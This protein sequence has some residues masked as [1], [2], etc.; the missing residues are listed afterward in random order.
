M[1]LNGVC[2]V[3]AY[4]GKE[5]DKYVKEGINLAVWVEPNYFVFNRLIERTSKYNIKNVWLPLLLSDINDELVDFYLTNNEESSSFM[6]LGNKHRLMYPSITIVGKIKIITKRFDIY[7]LNQQDFSWS[8]I[9]TLV[10]DCQG[11]DLKVL[12]GFGD[13]LNSPSLKTIQAEV[14]FGNMYINNPTEEEI[15]EFLKNYGFRKDRWFIV[16]NGSWGDTTW[17]RN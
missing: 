8:D 14:N 1:G 13:L 7:M 9:S 11:A 15:N 3:G 2:H 12:K 10:V 5:I 16:D 6:V 17:V 4:D